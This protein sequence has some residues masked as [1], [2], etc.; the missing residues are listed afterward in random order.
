VYQAS[1][2][3]WLP[4]LASIRDF[5]PKDFLLLVQMKEQMHD[6]NSGS[7]SGLLTR[8][9]E[10]FIQIEKKRCSVSLNPG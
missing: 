7:L 1:T 6:N 5:V 3:E 2:A 10:I 8:I 9:A 4:Y